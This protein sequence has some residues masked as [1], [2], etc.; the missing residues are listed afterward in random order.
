MLQ[1]DLS[2]PGP[3]HHGIHRAP[4]AM[5][6]TFSQALESGETLGRHILPSTTVFRKFGEL[7]PDLF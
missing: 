2:S 1:T 4:V 6:D 5:S 3:Y 7:F